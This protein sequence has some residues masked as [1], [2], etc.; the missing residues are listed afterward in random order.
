MTIVLPNEFNAP[1]VTTV[2]DNF[3]MLAQTGGPALP[4]ERLRF[5]R[6]RY[7]VGKD[8]SSLE[9]GTRLEA[10]DTSEAWVKFSDG[11]VAEQ[12][13]RLPGMRFPERQELPDLDE[14]LWP[15]GL[16]GRPSD[17]WILNAY[18]YLIEPDGAREF[19]FIGGSIGGRKAVY[20]LARQVAVKRRSHRGVIP[21]VELA[22]THWTSKA[23]GQIPAPSFTVVDWLGLPEGPGADLMDEEIPF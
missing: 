13:E 20:A 1:A 22:A 16:D 14:H 12:I 11:R 15:T 21:I 5:K 17:P 3:G 10:R 8:E 18:L 6:G 23:Y 9:L 19:T 2:T 4:G 7:V